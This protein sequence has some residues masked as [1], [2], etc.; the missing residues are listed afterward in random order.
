[1]ASEAQ[2][3]ANRK[4]RKQ[5]KGHS[6]EGLKRLSAA[7]R[8]NRPWIC[9]TGPKTELGKVRSK[10]NALRHGGRSESVQARLEVARQLRWRL[11]ANEGG[12]SSPIYAA[13]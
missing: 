3:L 1:M 6:L 10:M 4:N 5:W 7:A 13:G 12:E 8:K 11:L 9:S 2:I